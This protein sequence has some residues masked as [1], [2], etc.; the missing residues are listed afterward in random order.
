[1]VGDH[2]VPSDTG[3]EGTR[4]ILDILTDLDERTL[5][6]AVITGGASALLTAPVDGISLADLQYTTNRL[7]ESGA[8]IADITA[9]RKHLSIIK[10]GQLAHIASPA[11][12]VRLV[13][14]DVVGNDLSVIASGPTVPDPSTFTDVQSVLVDNTIQRLVWVD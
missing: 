13:L 6:L 9:V 11:T 12:V 5:V 1:M 10:G 2:P 7:L 14:S 4:T 3:V 8:E